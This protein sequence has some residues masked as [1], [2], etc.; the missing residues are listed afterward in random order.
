METKN[1]NSIP[2]NYQALLDNIR[3]E[4]EKVYHLNM[5]PALVLDAIDIIIHEQ[6]GLACVADTLERCNP[7]NEGLHVEPPP[8]EK[9]LWRVVYEIDVYAPNAKAAAQKTYKLMTDPD[10][11]APVL[12]VLGSQGHQT[13]VDLSQE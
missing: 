7:S 2:I 4:L 8:Q 9:D 10:S 6:T 11:M 13:R 5:N 12:D 1:E 3:H